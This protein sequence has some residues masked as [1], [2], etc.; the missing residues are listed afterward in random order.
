MELVTVRDVY[1]VRCRIC[2]NDLQSMKM[3][4]PLYNQFGN[5]IEPARTKHGLQAASLHRH[6]ISVES[7]TKLKTEHLELFL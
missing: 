3:Q 6:N 2:L 7:M 4:L 5:R 1:G